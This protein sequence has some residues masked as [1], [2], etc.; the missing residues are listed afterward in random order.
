MVGGPLRPADQITQ[1]ADA[2]EA[3]SDE[4]Q[5]DAQCGPPIGCPFSSPTGQIAPVRFVGASL[6]LRF[7]GGAG[8]GVGTDRG[9]GSFAEFTD[10]SHYIPQL[11]SAVG[12]RVRDA[13][14]G[15]ETGRDASGDDA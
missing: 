3:E 15:A 13:G 12:Q 1:S 10:I 2:D 14:D 9:L 4:V 11:Y 7:T 8:C 5:L 6:A